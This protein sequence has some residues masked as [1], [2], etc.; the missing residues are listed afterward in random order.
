MTPTG[1]E[2]AGKPPSDAGDDVGL[3]DW[4][5]R[6]SDFPSEGS[7]REQL[8]FCVRYALLAP[9]SHNTQPWLFRVFNSTIELRADRTRALPVVDPFDRELVISCGAALCNLSLAISRFGHHPDIEIL[10]DASDP[11]LLARVGL[12]GPQ[13]ASPLTRLLFDAILARRTNR[14]AFDR[15]PVDPQLVSALRRCALIEGAW[16]EEV[17][18]VK[19]DAVAE[20]I[21][22]ADRTQ[23][24][25]LHFRRELAA[26]TNMEGH[27]RRDGIP[28]YPTPADDFDSVPATLLV[29]TFASEDPDRAARDRALAAGSPLLCVL[30]TDHEEPQAWMAAGQALERL[31]LCATV[32][33]LTA[34]FLNQ[35]VEVPALRSRLRG[36]LGRRGFPQL[37]LRIGFG[38]AQRPTPRRELA[39]VLLD[40]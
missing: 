27:A 20:L 39:D 7:E 11:D 4:S 40:R 3:A 8:L 6:P 1:F 29:R 35:P 36:V 10:P 19:K 18:G 28:G 2:S 24:R 22:E 31:W 37:I 9:S 34:S 30:G 5:I 38:G 21:A 14:Q 26:W 32:G 23:M 15:R 12:G 25:D 13:N 16:L 17:A 33:G